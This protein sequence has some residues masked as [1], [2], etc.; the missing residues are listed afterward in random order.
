MV[1][2]HEARSRRESRSRRT[3]PKPRRHESR[4]SPMPRTLR[5]TGNGRD[6]PTRAQRT[7]TRTR[8]AQATRTRR[9]LRSRRSAVLTVP[10]PVVTGAG[11][12]RRT[13]SPPTGHAS[14]LEPP[15]GSGPSPCPATETNTNRQ[16][17]NPPPRQWDL[18]VAARPNPNHPAT[19][20]P[21]NIAAPS[22]TSLSL[23]LEAQPSPHRE[24]DEPCPPLPHCRFRSSLS[25]SGF[26]VGLDVG[27]ER[28]WTVGCLHVDLVRMP[29]VERSHVGAF[30][31]LLAPR[32][33]PWVL[34]PRPW[35]GGTF[36]RRLCR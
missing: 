35:R 25:V 24:A 15:A 10:V 36:R 14:Q 4:E 7:G 16:P 23:P 11:R 20:K 8:A 27:S 32:R 13:T 1:P 17:P 6:D 2:E 18:F 30:L 22:P 12:E 34:R 31:W 19:G 9:A 5:N 3:S 29:R 21:D 33:C 26:D 28:N